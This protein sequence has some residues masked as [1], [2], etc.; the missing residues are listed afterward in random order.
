MTQLRWAYR[1][2]VIDCFSRKI[3]GWAM[4]D[5]DRTPGLVQDA[6]R[7]AARNMALPKGVVFPFGPWVELY[8]GMITRRLRKSSVYVG[9]WA[10][11]VFV[12]TIVC[13]SR[14]TGRPGVELVNR[15]E[16]PTRAD[17]MNAVAQYIELFYNSKRL[18]S[19]LGYRT[20]QEVLA[21]YDETQHT[22]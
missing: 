14:R 21:E 3:I 12:T 13:R 9:R 19:M 15:E 16:Y 2:L 1:A 22:A 18:H 7:M 6:I 5:N 11:L 8:A 20:P 17:A 10:G 4:A